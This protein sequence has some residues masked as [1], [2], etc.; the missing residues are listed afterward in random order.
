LPK[1][2]FAD[3]TGVH[4]YVT[5]VGWLVCFLYCHTF[6]WQRLSQSNSNRSP[7]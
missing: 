3:K 1:Q 2:A 5:L 4:V 6:P 7:L